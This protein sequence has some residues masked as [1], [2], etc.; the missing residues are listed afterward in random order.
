MD[1]LMTSAKLSFLRW[2]WSIQHLILT[3]LIVEL[4]YK[5]SHGLFRWW[6][7]IID[8]KLRVHVEFDDEVSVSS[9]TRRVASSLWRNISVGIAHEL[10]YHAT[11]QLKWWKIKHP[12]GN[13]WREVIMDYPQWT[14]ALWIMDPQLHDK[15]YFKWSIL[16]GQQD[17]GLMKYVL[18]PFPYI[19]FLFWEKTE[20]SM[21]K[22]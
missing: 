4:H 15:I 22:S 2:F 18:N 9:W 20:E 12:L 14:Q 6:R 13:P 21:T 7:W 19:D 11:Q 16:L 8:S 5:S 17:I 10:I 3:I 1:G